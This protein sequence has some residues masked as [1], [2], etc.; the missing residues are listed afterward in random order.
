M[1]DDEPAGPYVAIILLLIL[2]ILCLS[3]AVGSPR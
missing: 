1:T 2:I 3:W